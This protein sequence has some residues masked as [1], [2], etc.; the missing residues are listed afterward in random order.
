MTLPKLYKRR[1]DSGIQ[2]WSIEVEGCGYRTHSGIKDGTIVVSDWTMVRAKSRTSSDEQCLKDTQSIW[3]KKVKSGGYNE[4]I[5][6]VDVAKFFK[7]MLA[8]KW[9]DE[10]R[11][12]NYPV[13][14]QPKL[15][16]VRCIATKSG[17]WTRGGERIT[18]MPHVEGALRPY[19]IMFPWMVLDGEAYGDKFAD[20]FNQLLSIVRT[21]KPSLFDI[22]ASKQGI[23]YAVFDSFDESQPDMICGERISVSLNK[24][25]SAVDF[26]PYVRCVRSVVVGKLEDL[27]ELL[28]QWLAEGYEGQMVRVPSAKY[29]LNHRSRYLLKRKEFQDDEFTIVDVEEGVGNRAGMAGKFV[30][31]TAEGTEFRAGI[32][33]NETFFTRLLEKRDELIGEL[34][35]VRYQNLTPDERVPRFG[36]VTKVHYSV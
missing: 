1:H 32:R 21:Q 22:E 29:E 26:S 28:Q 14:A 11:R 12:V 6:D 10:H 17:L 9:E 23:H 15:D 13:I 34:A 31:K 20:D 35:T 27:D 8:K 33:G 18:S 7:P 30:F 36:V 19:F 3:N 4:S 25:V 24:L 5:E 16:G 2:E